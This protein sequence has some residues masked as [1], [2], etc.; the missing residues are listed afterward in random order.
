MEK[1]LLAVGHRV[2]EEYLEKIL[3]NEF[4]FVGNTTYREGV[5]RA[6]GQ[7]S[8]DVV[9]LRETLSGNENIMKIVYQI[10]DSFPRVRIVFIAGNREIGDELLATLVN[11][12]VYDI[13]VGS[14]IPAQRIVSHIRKGNRYSDVKHYQPAP[15]LDE[16]TNKVLFTAPEVNEESH[17]EA[18]VKVKPIEIQETFEVAPELTKDVIQELTPLPEKKLSMLERFKLGKTKE[19]ETIPET[20]VPKVPEIIPVVPEVI[21]PEIIAPE[22]IFPEKRNVYTEEDE[23]VP[24]RKERLLDKFQNFTGI[25]AM[26]S[27][28]I[29]TFVG[30]KSGVGTTSIAVN[31]AVGLAVKGHKVLFI[32]VDAVSPTSSYWYELGILDEGIETCLGALKNKQFDKVSGAIVRMETLKKMDLP[33]KASYKKFPSTMDFLFYSKKYVAGLSAK[34]ELPDFKELYLY[35][36]YQMGYD[37][38]V[39]DLST[40]SSEE[41]K[42]SALMYSNKIFSVLTQDVSSLGYHL[43]AIHNLEKMGVSIT[44]KNN[45]IVNRYTK[46]SFGDKE[47][48]EWLQTK[49]LILVPE[50]GKELIESNLKGLPSILHKNSDFS[51]AIEKVVRTILAK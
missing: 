18:P 9:V 8:P 41:N 13:L 45:Y 12:G 38:V 35:L 17:K 48:K 15:S 31:A 27:E 36:M 22:T 5:V 43:A 2:L 40:N 7:N 23:A 29:I 42:Q 3:K 30:G 21:V 33:M 19:T 11:Y 44:E 34:D 32:E 51:S 14:D 46:A 10:R 16:K 26:A 47:I 49:E 1:V 20:A 24:K 50:S 6:I 37:F 4:L 39:I 25:G 28:R